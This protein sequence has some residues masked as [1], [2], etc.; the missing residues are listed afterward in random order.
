MRERK[1]AGLLKRANTHSLLALLHV[2]REPL[3]ALKE[4]LTRG[5]ATNQ[6]LRIGEATSH[7]DGRLTLGG[8]T[9]TY[10]ASGGD[11]TSP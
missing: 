8:H 4:T 6:T 1:N 11:P 3:K 2:L 7:R 10:R 9:M 5:C